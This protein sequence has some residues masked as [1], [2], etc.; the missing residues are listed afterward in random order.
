LAPSFGAS[1]QCL[2]EVVRAAKTNASVPITEEQGRGANQASVAVVYRGRRLRVL[3]VGSVLDAIFFERRGI[4]AVVIITA[5][6][7]STAVRLAELAAMPGYPDAV[8]PD[9]VGSLSAADVCQPSPRTSRRSCSEVAS[10]DPV[11]PESRQAVCG[12]DGSALRNSAA[13][14]A[15]GW[16]SNSVRGR[17]ASQ[18]LQ[19]HSFVTSP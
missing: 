8:I 14:V 16:S 3:L 15:A 17:P 13:V 4:P 6:F 5:P 18:L 11:W 12:H 10:T 2:G 19:I 9:P 1:R 7:V